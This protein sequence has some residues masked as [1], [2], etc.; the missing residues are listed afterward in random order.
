MAAKAKPHTEDVPVKNRWSPPQQTRR[1]SPRAQE[2][3]R[4]RIAH[5]TAQKRRLELFVTEPVMRTLG[6]ELGR[7]VEVFFRAPNAGLPFQLMVRAAHRGLSISQP[8]RKSRTG[9]VV[10]SGGPISKGICAPVR[11]LSY[12]IQNGALVVDLPTAWCAAHGID[13][14][15]PEGAA[16]TAAA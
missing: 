3:V 9:R 1:S 14:E 5:T 13:P 6:W 16:Q 7:T 12:A 8:S 15:A 10:V 11:A 2:E 4:A